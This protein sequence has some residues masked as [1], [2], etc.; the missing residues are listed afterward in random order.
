MRIA[1]LGAGAIGSA[2]G[3]LLVRAGQDVTLIGRPDQVRAMQESGLHV[4]GS[5]GAFT[6]RVAVATALDF[7]PDLALLAVK[8]QDVE[9]AVREYHARLEGVPL[10]TLQNGIRSDA[11]VA[12]ILPGDDLLSAVVVVTATYLTPGRVT[13]VD[14]GHLVL[15]RPKGPHDALVET[16]AAVL[17]KALPT[18]ISDN[19]PGAHWFK[20]LMNLN[21]A[22]PALTNLPLREVTRDPFLRRLAI[23]LMREGLAVADAA[24]VPLAPLSGV[25]VGTVRRIT[26]LPTRL[27]ARLFAARAGRLG[28]GWPVLGSTLQSLRRGRITEIDYLNG[29]IVRRGREFGI[30]TPWNEKVVELVHSVERTGHYIRPEAVRGAFVRVLAD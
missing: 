15:G 16:M 10:V 1:M 14:R 18:S 6:L 30:A 12:G 29:E 27:A 13:I 7:R 26:R 20:L 24:G 9:P 2:I 25:S 17:D 22:I 23:R 4:D 8:T 19:M 5:A 3:A 28:K 11:I 21:N